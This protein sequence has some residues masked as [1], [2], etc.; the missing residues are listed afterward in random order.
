MGSKAVVPIASG[1]GPK[2]LDLTGPGEESWDV[3]VLGAGLAGLTLARHL[4]L[5][6]DLRVLIL[7]RRDQLPPHR[8]KVGES[9]VQVAGHYFSRVLELEHHLLHEHFMKYN[10]RFYWRSAGKAGRLGRAAEDGFE[11]YSASYIRPFSNVPSY[12]LDRNAFES[13]L[14][15][16]AWEN[17]LHEVAPGVEGLRVELEDDPEKPHC[18]HFTSGGRRRRA[19]CRW[20][21]DATGRRRFV[22]K[23]RELRRPSSIRHGA[24]FWWVDG[25]VDPEQL[26]GLSPSEWRKHPHRRSLGHLPA[27]L[28][29]NHFCDE[30]L[31]F[32]VI[33]LRGKT[34]LG[35]VF[36]HEVV[37]FSDVSH[38]DKAIRWVCERFP[39]F[40]RI[41]R[42][43]KVL[44]WSGLKSYAHDS[45]QAIHPSRWALT[46]EAGRFTDPL[47]SPGSDL[48]SIHNTLIVDAILTG[49]SAELARKCQLYESMTKAVYQ[50][51]VPS[52]AT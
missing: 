52:Y 8:Q 26:T 11:S 27:W 49:D 18:V 4:S 7:E 25:T 13:E 24:F 23:Q 43:R 35:L 21:V 51:Y 29:T 19:S 12:Q 6:S 3:V 41:L 30:G 50:A 2:R 48:I 5:R 14:L 39:L 47:Y 33:P 32:W 28:A 10:L 34:S 40:A 36:D 37:N 20:L 17:P 9:S 46:G 45:A 16:L 22:A 44:D 15:R 31:W 38:P 1:E 42:D